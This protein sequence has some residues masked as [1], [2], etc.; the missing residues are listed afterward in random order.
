VIDADRAF[1]DN[2]TRISG[3]L[4]SFVKANSGFGPKFSFWS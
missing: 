4:G 1:V 2:P 3:S